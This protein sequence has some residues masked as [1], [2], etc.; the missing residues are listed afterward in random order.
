MDPLDNSVTNTPVQ[1]LTEEDH[2]R[3][4]SGRRGSLPQGPSPFIISTNELP[5]RNEK[6]ASFALSDTIDATLIPN[7]FDRENTESTLTPVDT[8]DNE[9]PQKKGSGRRGSLPQARPSFLN[10]VIGKKVSLN[11]IHSKGYA[12]EDIEN[13]FNKEDR[14]LVEARKVER[15][16]KAVEILYLLSFAVL[17]GFICYNLY[18]TY[19]KS[20]SGTTFRTS[21][22]SAQ[23]FPQILFGPGSNLVDIAEPLLCTWAPD[24]RATNEM[25]VE[26]QSRYQGVSDATDEISSTGFRK[27]ATVSLQGTSK[28]HRLS[29]NIIA[30][31]KN[32]QLMLYIGAQQSER[33]RG[34]INARY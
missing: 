4:A 12:N 6:P 15:Y 32:H 17:G 11:K 8:T 1:K 28:Y 5:A 18:D 21:V 19:V 2:Q 13:S 7:S 26:V 31:S 27:C 29:E 23:S 10:S 9:N 33:L 20:E 3:K 22:S 30:G 16:I 14:L 34:L 24:N 25:W